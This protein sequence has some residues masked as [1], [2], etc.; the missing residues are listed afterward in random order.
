MCLG[1]G[2]VQ[3]SWRPSAE[4]RAGDECR[5]LSQGNVCAAVIVTVSPLYPQPPATSTP[6]PQP[7]LSIFLNT[8][9]NCQTN[10]NECASNP[11]LNQGT[12]IDDVAGYT[13]NCLLPYTGEGG[14]LCPTTALGGFSASHV[15]PDWSPA[16]AGTKHEG[17]SHSALPRGCPQPGLHLSMAQLE[18]M[19]RSFEKLPH[20]FLPSSSSSSSWR[21]P[22]RWLRGQQH[23]GATPLTPHCSPAMEKAIRGRGA[24]GILLSQFLFAGPG[25]SAR[26]ARHNCRK[27]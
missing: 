5:R 3:P 4:F 1:S 12:C 16:H 19:G 23:P 25:A 22:G 15:T 7:L 24:G 26:A 14:T 27:P 18:E 9:P 6:P 10:I 2:A 20:S 21:A 17:F 8:G 11:C 13:C